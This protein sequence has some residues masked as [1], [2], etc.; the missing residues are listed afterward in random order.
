MQ[1]HVL[2]I[3][4]LHQ[5]IRGEVWSV[6]QQKLKFLDEF[7]SYPDYYDRVPV[8]VH[9]L[10]DEGRMTGDQV[11]ANIYILKSSKPELLK[12]PFLSNYDSYGSHNMPYHERLIRTSNEEAADVMK[13]IRS[14]CRTDIS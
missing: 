10:D 4:L 12:L 2:F 13:E 5:N 14:D 6:D 8:H 11:Q 7:E 9:L 3:L 1:L